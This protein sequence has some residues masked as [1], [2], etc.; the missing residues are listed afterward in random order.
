MVET[1]QRFIREI[2]DRVGLDNVTE[3]HLFPPMRQ[4][5]IET[6]VAVIAAIV[7][8]HETVEKHTV[9]SA[10]YRH[11]IK[12]PDRGKWEVDVRAEADAPLATVDDVVRGV[13]KRA[14]E[15]FEP[16]RLS[17]GEVR[18]VVTSDAS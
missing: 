13:M 14:G 4:G 15:Q 2:A 18:T 5:G 11:T 8:D 6:G 10:N 1:T 7:A 9:F 3:V 17:A 16:E 12:G